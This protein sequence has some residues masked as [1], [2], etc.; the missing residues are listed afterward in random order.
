M[1]LIDVISRCTNEEIIHLQN[2]E[3][4]FEC[5][6]RLNGSFPCSSWYHY[7]VLCLYPEELEHSR[8]LLIYPDNPNGDLC[9]FVEVTKNEQTD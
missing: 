3:D 9:L 4:G 2:D 6:F 5:Y 8:T 7:D 1:K